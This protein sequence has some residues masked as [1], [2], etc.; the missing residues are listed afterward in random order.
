MTPRGA[1]TANSHRGV[2]HDH[3]RRVELDLTG[4]GEGL[5][6][7]GHARALGDDAGDGE[8]P[9]REEHRGGR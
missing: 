3:A 6:H 2:H 1:V 8:G 9:R 4:G 5:G 7:G